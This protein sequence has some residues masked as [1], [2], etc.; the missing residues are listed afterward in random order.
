[1]MLRAK[2][3]AQ[4]CQRLFTYNSNLIQWHCVANAGL[5]GLGKMVMLRAKLGAAA[6]AVKNFFTGGKAEQDPAVKAMEAL[7]VSGGVSFSGFI[8]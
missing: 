6:G 8:F 4:T 3:G 5:Q 7:R 1:M 2:L